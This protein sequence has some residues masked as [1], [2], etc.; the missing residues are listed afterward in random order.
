MKHSEVKYINHKPKDLFN[1]VCD[2]KNYPEF[3]PWCLGARV[4]HL[5]ENNFN[6]DLVVGFKIYREVFK[7]NICIN[8]DK[9]EIDVN[10]L[11]GPFEHLI[12]K[13]KFDKSGNGCNVNF[14]VEFT[15]NTKVL[16]SILES[17]FN[18]AVLKMVI[19]FEKRANELYG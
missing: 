7:S 4:K 1:L 2:V 10:Y 15:L 18:E 9:Y 14:L 6:A 13:W 17:F 5:N 8:K 19:A 12:N 16:N 11:D 3:L